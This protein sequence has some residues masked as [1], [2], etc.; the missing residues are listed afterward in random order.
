M[1]DSLFYLLLSSLLVGFAACAGMAALQYPFVRWMSRTSSIRLSSEFWFAW[2]ILPI[3]MGTFLV[4]FALAFDWVGSTG[5]LAN[6]HTQTSPQGGVFFWGVALG[7]FAVVVTAAVRTY[8]RYLPTYQLLG[9]AFPEKTANGQP[10][11]FSLLPSGFPAVFTAGLFFPRVYLTQA[12]VELLTVQEQ[13]IVL[14]HENEH[15]R[16]KDPLRLLLLT[17]CEYWLPGVRYL[18]QQWQGKVEIECDLASIK[19]GFAADRVA[20][21]ILKFERAK[22]TGCSPAMS[23]AYAPKNNSDLKLRIESLFDKSPG[24][25]G[26]APVLSGCVALCLLL[27]VNFMEVHRGVKVFLGWLN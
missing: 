24:A 5:W 10:V 11:S 21:T 4:G 16:R 17:F 14:S 9:G 3:L 7:C 18:R 25:I 6:P 20:S 27:V 13:D 2:G 8:C 22:A 19:L 15:I 12:A 1:I 26:Q 23:L